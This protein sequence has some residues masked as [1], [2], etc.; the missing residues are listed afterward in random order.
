MTRNL[1]KIVKLR[2]ILGL[3]A[4]QKNQNCSKFLRVSQT[5]DTPLP[6]PLWGGNLL[7]TLTKTYGLEK[8][9]IGSHA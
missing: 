7:S 4:L 9:C 8:S 2:M 3:T 1:S 5:S 6:T